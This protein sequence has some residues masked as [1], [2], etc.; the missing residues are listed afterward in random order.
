MLAE[1]VGVAD[2][3]WSR[4]RGLIGRP[5]LESG[6]ALLIEPCDGVHTF[7]MTYALDLLFLDESDRVVVALYGMKPWRT[8]RRYRAR[9]VLELPAGTLAG[10]GVEAGDEIYLAN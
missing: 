8:T 6:E 9:K 5:P 3:F 7:F 10:I 4:L 2:R 1:R